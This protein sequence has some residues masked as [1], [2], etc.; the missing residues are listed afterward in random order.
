MLTRNESSIPIKMIFYQIDS[1]RSERGKVLV[2]EALLTNSIF[3]ICLAAPLTYL[4]YTLMPRKQC[5]HHG[6]S[7]GRN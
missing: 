4:T 7:F 1:S 6:S 5:R 2:Q 3:Y